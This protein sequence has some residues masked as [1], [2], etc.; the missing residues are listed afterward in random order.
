MGWW[1]LFSNFNSKNIFLDFT[2]QDAKWTNSNI[3]KTILTLELGL[4]HYF[5]CFQPMYD[6][7][8]LKLNFFVMSFLWF[9]QSLGKISN[10]IVGFS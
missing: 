7:V 5:L 10:L 3:L 2:N 6:V 8:R 1:K 9:M 4:L